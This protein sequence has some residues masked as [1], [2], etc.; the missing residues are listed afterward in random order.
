MGTVVELVGLET[1]LEMIFYI[2]GGAALVLFRNCG[3]LR[4]QNRHGMEI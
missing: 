1:G 2:L 3:M 4:P